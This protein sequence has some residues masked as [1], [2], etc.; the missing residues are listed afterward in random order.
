[1]S[2]T[3]SQSP[4]F[5]SFIQVVA[6]E[7][8]VNAEAVGAEVAATEEPNSTLVTFS[9]E[10]FEVLAMLEEIPAGV[11]HDED[12]DT[13]PTLELGYEMQRS[14]DWSIIDGLRRQVAEILTASQEAEGY[15]SDEDQEIAGR[16]HIIDVVRAYV[17]R[18]VRTVGQTGAWKPSMQLAATDAVFN[19]LFRLGRLQPLLDLPGVENVDINGFDN[20][21]VSFSDGRKEKKDPI[22]GSDAEFVADIQ[23]LASRAGAGGRAWTDSATILD[24]DLPGGARLA[25]VLNPTSARPTVVIRVHRLV[26]ITLDDLVNMHQTVPRAAADFLEKVVLGGRSI[27]ISGFPGAGKTTLTR[28][29]ANCL[30]ED[31]KIVT[32]EK[33]REL[34]LHTLPGH[35]IVNSLQYRPGSGERQADG[36]RPGE[37]SM[38]DLLEE[39]LRLN[40]QRIIVGEVRGK[41]INAMFQ[42]MQA[43]VGSFSTIHAASARNAVER[44]ATLMLMNE[45]VTDDY[46]YRQIATNIDF[47]VQITQVEVEGERP[48][49]L[50]TEI[51]E[52]VESEEHSRPTTRQLF[53]MNENNE[54]VSV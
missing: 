37:V 26:N 36:S 46:A 44:M 45:G 40:A 6:N 52:V 18:T 2:N 42:A 33:E 27:V 21:W 39:A 35:N 32:I 48:R 11:F 7:E 53:S 54:L 24:M 15:I 3:L 20:V 9:P 50:I 51:V 34:Y 4:F 31:V 1:M 16:A 49:R 19:S 14:L 29:L 30:P 10:D 8:A 28:A 13:N 25:A 43:G 12:V 38:I 5:A 22:A 23:F 17:E 47:I 41:E